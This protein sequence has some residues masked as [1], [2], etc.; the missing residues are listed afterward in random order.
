MKRVIAMRPASISR[1]VTQPHSV[2]FRPKS[3]NEREPPV[4]ALPFMRPRCCLRYL[5]FFGINMAAVPC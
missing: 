1:A 4:H 3:P 2:A 5:T